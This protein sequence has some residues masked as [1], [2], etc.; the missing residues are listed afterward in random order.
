MFVIEE[1]N[2]PVGLVRF[3][4]APADGCVISV[5]LLEQ[6]TGRGL[7]VEAI[8]QGCRVLLDSW[9]VEEV[10]ACV[11]RENAGAQSAFAKAGFVPVESN[12]CPADHVAMVLKEI[13]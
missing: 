6:F 4:R 10:R 5:Y 13:R 11:R 1:G 3:D 9:S 7:G 2:V 8:R 12:F